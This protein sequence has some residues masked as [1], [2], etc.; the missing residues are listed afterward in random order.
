MT[1]YSPLNAGIPAVCALLFGEIPAAGSLPVALDGAR[2]FVGEGTRLAFAPTEVVTETDVPTITLTPSRTP[3]PTPTVTRTPTRE[4]L[5]A[6]TR[7]A[8]ILPTVPDSSAASATPSPTLTLM[9]SAT[10]TDTPATVI[11]QAPDS[12][13]VQNEMAPTPTNAGLLVLPDLPGDALGTA[14]V[15]GLGMLGLAYVGLYLRGATAR[16][17]YNQGFIIERCPACGKEALRVKIQRKRRLG[18]PQAK[19]AVR[20]DTCRSVL[21]ET[22]RGQWIY[23]INPRANPELYV[24]FHDKVVDD[25]TLRTLGRDARDGGYDSNWDDG[26]GDGAV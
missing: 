13:A 26:D 9:P 6:E 8:S 22:S 23:R 16:R 10:L 15:S 4:P 20:C 3:T 19:Y 12:G 24:R 18:I 1:T 14:V 21:R 11:A 5:L 25:A 7:P 17:R 2:E